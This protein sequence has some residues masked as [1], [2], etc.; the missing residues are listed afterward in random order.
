M[1]ERINPETVDLLTKYKS[2]LAL[3]LTNPEVFNS[4][5]SNLDEESRLEIN[6]FSQSLSKIL[7]ANAQ[8]YKDKLTAFA[9]RSDNVARD[10]FF[11]FIERSP[12]LVNFFNK[13]GDKIRL[14]LEAMRETILKEETIRRGLDSDLRKLQNEEKKLKSEL[15]GV[16][17]QIANSQQEIESLHSEL[18]TAS[19][20]L[21]ESD[22]SPYLKSSE[23]LVNKFFPSTW[24]YKNKFILSPETEDP[25]MIGRFL[26]KQQS[27]L[28]DIKSELAQNK[29]STF[30]KVI[31]GI[32][33]FFSQLGLGKPPHNDKVKKY[34]GMQKLVAN[35]TSHKTAAD[36]YLQYERISSD[37]YKRKSALPNLPAIKAYLETKISEIGNKI[38]RKEQQLKQLYGEEQPKVKPSKEEEEEEE[39]EGE[40]KGP[41]P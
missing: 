21:R 25:L 13:N 15:E 33:S 35:A 1:V 11:K 6:Q 22:I 20:K 9:S 37:I 28:E 17:K 7:G 29:P 18:L 32:R 40:S 2:E 3:P 36:N 24:E 26:E 8:A 4:V 10:D 12:E 38:T 5:F 39:G 27:A 34:E 41:H 31:H 23:T 14:V 30:E 19:S 16:E